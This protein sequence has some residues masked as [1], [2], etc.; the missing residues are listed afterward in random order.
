MYQDSIYSIGTTEQKSLARLLSNSAVMVEPWL[1]GYVD[2]QLLDVTRQISCSVILQ[3]G[4]LINSDEITSG[5]RP[6]RGD[7]RS[8]RPCHQYRK[9]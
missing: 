9:A 7:G 5:L 2:A 1:I 6:E 3:V 8:L 4:L